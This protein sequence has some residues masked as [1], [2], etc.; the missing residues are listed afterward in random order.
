[1]AAHPRLLRRAPR[2]SRARGS[3]RP[4]PSW[5]TRALRL[6]ARVSRSIPRTR[7]RSTM[8]A[9]A[10]AKTVGPGRVEQVAMQ[11]ARVPSTIA[12]PITD[13]SSRAFPNVMRPSPRM[14]DGAR[15]VSGEGRELLSRPGWR[16]SSP[17]PS[18]A[19]VSAAPGRCLRLPVG[20]SPR[21]PGGQAVHQAIRLGD[22]YCRV[23]LP[24]PEKVPE[25]VWQ[26]FEERF[27]ALPRADQYL[28]LASVELA[29]DLKR[30]R[31]LVPALSDAALE[32]M[33]EL[34]NQEESRR[35][36]VEPGPPPPPRA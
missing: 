18:R 17:S 3:R 23:P 21:R 20:R 35:A 16:W 11:L 25:W 31:R 12:G 28:I 22:D 6:W 26:L 8:I 27:E 15:R 5:S 36:R 13:S 29:P 32:I 14:R 19:R 24:K 10:L 1:M 30:S 7:P 9:S 2:L 34:A 33:A 4:S